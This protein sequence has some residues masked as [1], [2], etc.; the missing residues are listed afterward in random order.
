MR[1][2]RIF[3]DQELQ[4]GTD[5]ILAEEAAHHVSR[6]LRLRSGHALILFDGRGGEPT[7]V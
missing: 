4:V 5:L 2:T 6:V 7:T 1:K 3:I